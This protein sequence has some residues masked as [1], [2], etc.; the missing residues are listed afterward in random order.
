MRA[1]QL[2]EIQMVWQIGRF[3]TLGKLVSAHRAQRP[4]LPGGWVLPA[5]W[6]AA[7][8]AAAAEEGSLLWNIAIVI[9][10]KRYQ[11]NMN[12]HTNKGSINIWRLTHQAGRTPSS[13][14]GGWSPIEGFSCHPPCGEDLIL[15]ARWVSPLR[16]WRRPP[17][18]PTARGGPTLQGGWASVHG[19]QRPIS[20]QVLTKDR[21]PP[22]LCRHCSV[23][24]F[25]GLT[26]TC[27][28]RNA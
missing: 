26:N 5:R 10:V 24:V 15:P 27:C 19:G 9:L 21:R 2:L 7:A 8:A 20:P 16:R 11:H 17:P 3:D 25:L 6:V 14:R 13:R 28:N 22:L 4:T 18:P 1:F 23:S 12:M